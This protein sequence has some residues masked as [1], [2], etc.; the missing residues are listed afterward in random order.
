VLPGMLARGRGKLIFISS[1]AG[2]QP[3]AN[4]AAYAASKGGLEILV[5]G[6]AE[7][8]RRH[9]VN[10]NAVAPSTIDTPANRKANPEGNYSL[11]VQ[12][13]SLAGVI[14]F[15]ASDAARDI[16]GAIVPVYGNA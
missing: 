11:W 6:L 13:E 1:R 15:L 3:A 2:S 10:V 16:H 4:E 14:G 8:T 5:R 12:P 9:G 7:E